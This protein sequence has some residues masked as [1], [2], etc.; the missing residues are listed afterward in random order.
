M[1]SYVSACSE[2]RSPNRAQP[3][4][5]N[6][7]PGP[8]LDPLFTIQEPHFVAS[9]LRNLDLTVRGTPPLQTCLNLLT[10]KLIRLPNGWLAF[11]WNALL[12]Y[13]LCISFMTSFFG[14]WHC[15]S[16]WYLMHENA[17]T[18]KAIWQST[19]DRHFTAWRKT[20]N[21]WHIAWHYYFHLGNCT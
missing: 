4:S 12:L 15:S 10:M 11:D 19:Y 18:R 8:V 16:G 7:P 1:S 21:G 17:K 6:W 14:A 20:I 13:S 2:E 9:L 3:P 5:P